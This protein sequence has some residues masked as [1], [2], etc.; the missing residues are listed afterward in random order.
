L[1]EPKMGAE[2]S[3]Q[4]TKVTDKP[5]FKKFTNFHP[6]YVYKLKQ[7]FELAKDAFTLTKED[8]KKLFHAKDEEIDVIFE[9]FDQDGDEV[10]DQFEFITGLAFLSH[11]SLEEKAELVFNMY[12][13]DKSQYISRDELT[14][15][16]TNSLCALRSLEQ[17]KPPEQAEIELKTNQFF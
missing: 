1:I 12:D 2:A 8:L 15:L 6:G 11:G 5:E 17:Q 10:I 7:R 4:T 13:F 3:K 16:M 9:H 14:I